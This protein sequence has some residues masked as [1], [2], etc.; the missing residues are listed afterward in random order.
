MDIIKTAY[1]LVHRC[2]DAECYR[3]AYELYRKLVSL[4]LSVEGDYLDCGCSGMDFDDLISQRKDHI[5]PRK[6]ACRM[7][8]FLLQVMLALV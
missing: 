2:V 1:G 5:H 7:N 3:E 6:F 8:L 4:E